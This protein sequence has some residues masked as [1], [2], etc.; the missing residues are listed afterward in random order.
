MM[1]FKVTDPKIA[2]GI[3]LGQF[4]D[5]LGQ[6]FFVAEI[7]EIGSPNEPYLKA[8]F[9]GIK[10]AYPI[11]SDYRPCGCWAGN[12]FSHPVVCEEHRKNPEPDGF[13]IDCRGRDSAHT[14]TMRPKK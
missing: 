14:D 13:F 7:S 11:N 6:G 2:E 10:E 3:K 8:W 1:R 9:I 5:I 4:F 12:S